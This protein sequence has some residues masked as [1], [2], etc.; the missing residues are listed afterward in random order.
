MA[1]LNNREINIMLKNILSDY[2]HDVDITEND[3]SLLIAIKIYN[4]NKVEIDIRKL[5]QLK[6]MAIKIQGTLE[7]NVEDNTL[8]IDIMVKK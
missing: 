1:T 8:F 3:K 4:A 6:L 7:S 2:L 5:I